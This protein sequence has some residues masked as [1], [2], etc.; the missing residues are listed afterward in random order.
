MA[1]YKPSELLLFLEELGIQ[2]KKGLS[3]NFLID[4]NIIRKIVS[5]A[6]VQAGDVVI[7]IGPGPGSLTEE[8]LK[9]GADVIAI[10]K[11]PI[12]AKALNRFSHLGGNLQVINADILD[13]ALEQLLDQHLKVGQKAKVI[14]NL[15]Y[16]IT[17]PIV[18]K[19]LHFH[20][21]ISDIVIMIQD[22]VAQRFVG[23]PSTHQYGSITV[24]LN[25]FCTP[26]YL[27]KVS[28]NCFYPIPNVDSAIVQLKLKIPP[29]VS[30]QEHFF[31]MTRKAFEQRRKMMRGSLK[32]LY[33][34]GCI[35]QALQAIGKTPE[36][37]PE[38]LSL[39]DFIA[40][41]EKLQTQKNLY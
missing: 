7:E 32:G 33:E 3:Q 16:H 28:R 12:L 19:L 9:A 38:E 4:G 11:D 36:A 24:F 23:K 25:F 27:F 21:L 30:S 41:F 10:E 2:P 18:T 15:P 1:I 13:C 5:S 20:L 37:R 34:S 6:D 35:E 8:L 14:A 22:E 29:S 26:K 40:L 17:T 31:K 39:E